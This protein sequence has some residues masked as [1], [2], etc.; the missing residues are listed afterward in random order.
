MTI[1]IQHLVHLSIITSNG[2]PNDDRNSCVRSKGEEKM[3][4]SRFSFV[5]SFFPFFLL[6]FWNP[7]FWFEI[8]ADFKNR[9]MLQ[10]LRIVNADVTET[11]IHSTKY[12]LVLWV[13]GIQ[14]LA[15]LSHVKSLA[16]ALRIWITQS[17]LLILFTALK[18]HY[19]PANHRAIH[20]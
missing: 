10:L 13:C 15:M 19:P 17:S 9:Q 3:S 16:I 12:S 14:N 5:P 20:L 7:L 2:I 6:S 11:C 1:K 4:M 8:F 18:S